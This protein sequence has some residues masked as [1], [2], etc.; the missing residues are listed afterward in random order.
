MR[1]SVRILF[2]KFLN[3]PEVSCKRPKAETSACPR[4]KARKIAIALHSLVC[5]KC[6]TIWSKGFWGGSGKG[7][8]LHSS[9]LAHSSGKKCFLT[10]DLAVGWAPD[11]AGPPG[12]HYEEK[13]HLLP[14]ML[15]IAVSLCNLLKRIQSSCSSRGAQLLCW[16]R[17]SPV[18]AAAGHGGTSSSKDKRAIKQ[19]QIVF[20]TPFQIPANQTPGTQSIVLNYSYPFRDFIKL[21]RETVQVL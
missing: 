16:G 21:H 15:W 6:Q 11:Q 4:R 10:P 20:K 8:M 12:S 19:N 7:T 1:G 9:V 2:Y 13:R 3:A 5:P 14:D 18:L 17:A